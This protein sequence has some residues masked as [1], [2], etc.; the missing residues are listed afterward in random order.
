MLARSS[1]P[2]CMEGSVNISSMRCGANTNNTNLNRLGTVERLLKT[3]HATWNLQA[4]LLQVAL[5]GWLFDG[6]RVRTRVA[7]VPGCFVRDVDIPA[8]QGTS[9]AGLQCNYSSIAEV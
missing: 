3:A 1:A 2:V 4:L 7:G 5:S 9:H 6:S 8:S